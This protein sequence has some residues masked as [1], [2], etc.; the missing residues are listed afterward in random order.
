MREGDTHHPLQPVCL[1]LPSSPCTQSLL[2]KCS[3]APN[4]SALSFHPL[5]TFL[6]LEIH[7]ML[8]CKCCRHDKKSREIH[9]WMGKGIIPMFCET[10]STTVP[11]ALKNK[12]C[13]SPLG[14]LKSHGLINCFSMKVS[15]LCPNFDI[16]NN[17]RRT[18][19]F[20]ENEIQN[21]CSLERCITKANREIRI[22]YKVSK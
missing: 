12:S 14:D 10:I 19:N 8:L 11:T 5:K 18:G 3:L 1:D 20:T 2:W 4:I 13:K 6:P 15:Q 7:S 22:H 17:G 16:G 9:Q 21:M